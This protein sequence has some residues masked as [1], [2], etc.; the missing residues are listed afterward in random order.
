MQKLVIIGTVAAAAA[1]MHPVNQEM[2]EKI[3]S[4]AT[5]WTPYEPH[6]NPFKDFSSEQIDAL[7]GTMIQ[8]SNGPETYVPPVDVST[9]PASFDARD[10]WGSCVHNIRD[11]ASCGSCWAFGSSEALSDRFCIAS[12]G[13]VDVVLSPQDLVSCD[14]SNMGC[15]GGYL[16]KAWDYLANTGIVTDS[17]KPYTSGNGS[18]ETCST[19]CSSGEAYKKYKCKSGSVVNPRTVANIKAELSTNGPLEGAFT[20]Y[21]DFLNYK[22]GVYQHTYGLPKGGHAIKVLGYGSENGVDYW[23][24]A[25]SWGTSWGEN[26]FFRIKQGDSGINQQMYGCTPEL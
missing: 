13:A 8:P 5:T 4:T 19:E 21:A 16:N 23:L 12:S 6:E 18:V 14:S 2:V 24:C 25:N 20:V 26:G 22:S 7:F 1:A 3:K 11:Q 10:Q 9:V 17:C 15:N